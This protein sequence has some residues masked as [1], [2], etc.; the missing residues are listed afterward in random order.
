MKTLTKQDLIN[1][2]DFWVWALDN[3]YLEKKA[4]PEYY[5]IEKYKN[6]CPFCSLYYNSDESCNKCPMTKKEIGCETSNTDPFTIWS[7]SEK[8]MEK[9]VSVQ[10]AIQKIIDVYQEE[11]DK[12]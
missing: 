2:R 11:I 8:Y 4:W 12:L 9:D 10:E 6:E 3:L 1:G 5:R 7:E